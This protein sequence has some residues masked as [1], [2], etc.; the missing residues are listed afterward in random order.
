MIVFLYPSLPERYAA[1]MSRKQLA[2]P[3]VEVVTIEN[4]S[5]A[6]RIAAKRMMMLFL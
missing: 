6:P 5:P 1:G 3:C 2:I 4:M